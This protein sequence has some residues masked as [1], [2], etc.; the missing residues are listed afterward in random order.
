MKIT[1]IS[2]RGD[3][4]DIFKPADFT[5]NDYVNSVYSINIFKTLNQPLQD[6]F[7]KVKTSKKGE[8]KDD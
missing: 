3:E 2:F 5:S 8:E 6:T 1:P 7:E 4:F